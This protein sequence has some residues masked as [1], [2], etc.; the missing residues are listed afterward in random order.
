MTRPAPGHCPQDIRDR[1][2]RHGGARPRARRRRA[3][4]APL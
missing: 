2:R 4:R 3:R 1:A